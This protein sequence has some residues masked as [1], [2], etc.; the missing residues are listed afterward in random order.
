MKRIKKKSGIIFFT[1]LVIGLLGPGNSAVA[2]P[3]G[4]EKYADPKGRF[5]FYYPS[6][7]GEMSRGTNSGFGNRAVALRFAKFSSG[8]QKGK[9]FL[10]G[11]AVLTKGRVTIDIQAAGGLYDSVS[12]EIFPG[13]LRKKLVRNLPA[14]S[15]SNLCRILGREGHIDLGIKSWRSL[16]EKMKNGI[17][18][19]DRM[20]N[21]KPKIIFCKVSGRTVSF[22]KIATFQ[23]GGMLS[24]QHIYGAVKFIKSPYSSFQ[25]VRGGKDPPGEM[26][27]D[28]M[29]E[30]VNS[31][32]IFH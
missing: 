8:M 1:A 10:G 29:T 23:A 30:L 15:A 21:L 5:V 17:R 9:L 24:R 27:V 2:Q 32:K 16:S 3:A 20:R 18:Q 26:A 13:P 11:E 22:H 28:S 4:W 12:M 6:R 25:F 7:F 31:I 19:I 14:L